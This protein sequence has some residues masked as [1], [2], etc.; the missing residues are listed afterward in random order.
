MAEKTDNVYKL[1]DDLI[2]AYKPAALKEVNEINTLA[3]RTEGNDFK[4]EPW[5]FSFY[6]HKLQM[7]NT[8]WTRKC[9]VHILNYP[10]L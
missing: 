1:L 9:C 6:S 3:K 10:K 2:D 7:E 8:I 5:D 4:M